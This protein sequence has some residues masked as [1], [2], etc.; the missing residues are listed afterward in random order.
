MSMRIIQ[1]HLARVI[2]ESTL[3]VLGV[4][5]SL[6]LFANLVGEIKDLGQGDYTIIEAMI[7]VLLTLPQQLYDLF[8]MAAMLG[9]LLGLGALSANSELIVLRGCGISIGQITQMVLKAVVVM[10]VIV[11]I[12]GVG[13]APQLTH[14]AEKRKLV[15]T[16]GGQALATGHGTWL[17]SGNN[18]LHIDDVLP[19]GHFAGIT[20]YAFDDAHRL[21]SASFAKTAEYKKDHLELKNLTTSY[22][23]VNRV[24]T[25]RLPSTT[26][27]MTL[28]PLFM[29]AAEMSPSELSL[30]KL[31][32][33]I[34]YQRANGLHT[35]E[36][37]LAFWQ[38][39]FKPLSSLVM[40][41]L[42]IPFVFGPLR[43]SSMGYK[44]MV[45]VVIG[46]SFYIVNEFFG[47]MSIVYQFPP[48]LGAMMPTLLF[49]ML[50]LFLI[51]RV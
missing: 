15:D 19:G 30:I 44:I 47:P 45:G 25:K 24:V 4:V 50:A 11:G 49:F 5:T 23:E 3:L 40:I 21:I 14:Y 41:F 6:L 22:F 28:N 48:L 38:R 46:F 16:T 51:R 29:H 10:I 20:W 42:A 9:V 35:S 13:L 37:V 18:F 33:F 31:Y 27:K 39:I 8:P 26:L 43:N 17:K 32:K 7:Y 34:H 1:T 36:F 2:I 12:L